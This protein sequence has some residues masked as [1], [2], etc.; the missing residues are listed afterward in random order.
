MTSRYFGFFAF[1]VSVDSVK[2]P[3]STSS[4]S[5]QF[6]LRTTCAPQRVM[7][8]VLVSSPA[9]TSSLSDHFICGC[10]PRPCCGPL[11]IHVFTRLLPRHILPFDTFFTCFSVTCALSTHPITPRTQSS[12]S[13]PF[14]YPTGPAV[15]CHSSCMW[16][17]VLVQSLPPCSM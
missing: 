8:P 1:F 9:F 17:G 16:C 4:S 13:F 2:C 7:Q 6:V 15:L 11:D 14:L 3:Y 12:L 5:N 10:G